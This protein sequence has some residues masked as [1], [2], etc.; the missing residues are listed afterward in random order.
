MPGAKHFGPER[1]RKESIFAQQ[2]S[3]RSG[4]PL[5][6]ITPKAGVMGGPRR[7]GTPRARRSDD[8]GFADPNDDPNADPND[9]PNADPNNDPNSDPNN[10]NST[11]LTGFL[12]C[13]AQARS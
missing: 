9:D 10:S 13:R 1:L 2:G 8:F 3:Y 12:F 11:K 4:K 5:H 7:C 6:P